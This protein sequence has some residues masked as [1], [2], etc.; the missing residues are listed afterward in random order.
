MPQ[1]AAD[2]TLTELAPRS[3]LGAGGDPNQT[4]TEVQM[5]SRR[6]LAGGATVAVLALAACGG[7][8][9]GLSKT[10]LA[11]KVN[12][13]CAKYNPQIDAVQIPSDFQSNPDSALAYLQ[14][15]R[16]LVGNRT[17]AIAKFKP[18]SSVKTDFT[19]YVAGSH[20]LV[21]VLDDVIAKAKS[22]SPAGL[23]EFAAMQGYA[24]TNVR[25]LA[26]K[27]GFTRCLA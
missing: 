6:T 11:S 2:V 18:A 20:H 15:V 1:R 5:H 4:P 24:N 3:R 10:Q 8:S 16:P 25:P 7:S 23:Q 13:V 26:Q 22:K 9:S 12:G 17:D 14:K 21:T 19:N 27:L